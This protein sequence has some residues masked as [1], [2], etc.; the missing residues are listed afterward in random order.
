[1]I[2]SRGPTELHQAREGEREGGGGTMKDDISFAHENDV[3]EEIE[4]FR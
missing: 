1:M 2:S 3:I 4:D